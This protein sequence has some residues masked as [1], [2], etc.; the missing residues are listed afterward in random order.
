MP[1]AAPSRGPSPEAFPVAGTVEEPEAPGPGPCADLEAV[2]ERV[3]SGGLSDEDRACLDERVKQ[4]D[5]T[6]NVLRLLTIEA[7]NR[8]EAEWERRAVQLAS[9]TEDPDLHYKLALH[10]SKREQPE[11]AL[12]HVEVAMQE[13]AAWPAG[14]VGA[15]T[16]RL[17]AV[18]IAICEETPSTVGCED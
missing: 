16:R 1:R 6:E 2:Y 3:R 14:V 5:D 11:A 18:R 7:W 10:F 4:D 9:I 15:R 13:S 17:D 12:H 8:D